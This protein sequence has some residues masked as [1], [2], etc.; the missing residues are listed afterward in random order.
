M[1]KEILSAHRGL[2]VPKGVLQSGRSLSSVR[3]KCGRNRT[4]IFA[5]ESTMTGFLP[6]SSSR[7]G[8]RCLAAAADTIFATIVLPSRDQKK[9]TNKLHSFKKN[10]KKSS[11][12]LSF[13]VFYGSHAGASLTYGTPD[14]FYG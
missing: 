3:Q 13:L 12:L 14:Y 10:K 4:A 5:V 8:V 11:L 6:P 9:T 2:V 7:T 1:K